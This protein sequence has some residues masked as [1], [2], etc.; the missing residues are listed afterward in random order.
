MAKNPII[1]PLLVNN[2]LIS[3]FREKAN[4]FNDAN[5]FLTIAFFQK[6][7]YSIHKIYWLWENFK[8]N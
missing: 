4:I 1:Q 7:K 2:S 8:I 6:I 3:K 5:P